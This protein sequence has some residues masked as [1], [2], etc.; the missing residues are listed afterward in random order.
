VVDK[1]LVG[2]VTQGRGTANTELLAYVEG[3]MTAFHLIDPPPGPRHAVFIELLGALDTGSV[4]TW[5]GALRPG[6]EG[7]RRRAVLGAEEARDGGRRR[8]LVGASGLWRP[9]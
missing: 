1:I 5:R 7:D 9:R 3:F 8:P 2:D 6:D 4:D